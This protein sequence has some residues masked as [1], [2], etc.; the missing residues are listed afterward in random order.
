MEIG[1]YLDMPSLKRFV[2]SLLLRVLIDGDLD[3]LIK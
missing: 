1:T 3:S 2:R